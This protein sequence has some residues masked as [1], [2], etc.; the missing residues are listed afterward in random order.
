MGT[1]KTF[2]E[3]QPAIAGHIVYLLAASVA[4]GGAWY[5]QLVGGLYPC[6][7]CLEQREP[8]YAGV[9]ISLLVLALPFVLPGTGE[10][11]LRG[12][13]P[14]MGLLLWGMYKAGDHIGVEQGWWG[15]G[16]TSADTGA[17]PQTIEELLA[18]AAT[19]TAIPC[20]AIQW[21]F[22][23]ITLAGYNFAL[24]V[25]LFVALAW[26]LRKALKAR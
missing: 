9:T 20:D 4:L 10:W 25:A 23:G 12:L 22:L 11:R 13:I 21:E 2:I 24:Q 1:I 15:A 18:G 16:C 7:L 17:G 3:R 14:N 8:W 26:F 6:E 5:L 19:D